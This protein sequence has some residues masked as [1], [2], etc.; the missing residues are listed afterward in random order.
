MTFFGNPLGVGMMIMSHFGCCGCCDMPRPGGHTGSV[1]ESARGG[2]NIFA[3]RR[4]ATPPGPRALHAGGLAAWFLFLRSIL[5]QAM[6]PQRHIPGHRERERERVCVR[7]Q[8]LFVSTAAARAAP[9]PQDHWDHARCVR[10]GLG[11]GF[12]FCGPF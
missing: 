11:R 9:R 3:L 7:G 8:Q 1:R 6:V 10:Q 2:K 5:V 4:S 12:V